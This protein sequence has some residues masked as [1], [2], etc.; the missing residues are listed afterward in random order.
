MHAA[1]HDALKMMAA[2]LQ[3]MHTLRICAAFARPPP[4]CPL[5]LHML[6]QHVPRYEQLATGSETVESALKDML[7]EFLNAEIALRTV[8]DI[9]Q[10]IQWLKST[11][12]Y[13]RV[14]QAAS[15][16]ACCA[17]L[18]YGTRVLACIAS[19]LLTQ[20]ALLLLCLHLQARRN[21]AHYGVPPQQQKS[22]EALERWMKEKLVLTAIR[23]LAKHG[24][25]SDSVYLCCLLCD[26]SI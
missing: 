14:R 15:N 8:A 5:V 22:H 21:P 17:V 18:C 11:F 9:S 4:R 25:A 26:R 20:P 24:L 19:M 16:V 10:A 13:V 23:E 2:I 6:S 7:P 3:C 1:T 12:F